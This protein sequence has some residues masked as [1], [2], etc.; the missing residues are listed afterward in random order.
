MK[1][2]RGLEKHL[3]LKEE[4]EER[5]KKNRIRLLLSWKMPVTAIWLF[6]FCVPELKLSTVISFH[7]LG[8]VKNSVTPP[9]KKPPLP[10]GALRFQ[11]PPS[12]VKE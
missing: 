2:L 5:G 1:T 8:Y 11:T 7:V 6:S 9:P 3:S 10:P 4:E 12:C